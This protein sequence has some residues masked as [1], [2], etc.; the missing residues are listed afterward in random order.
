MR[1]YQINVCHVYIINYHPTNFLIVCNKKCTNGS[2]DKQCTNCVCEKGFTGPTCQGQFLQQLPT[3]IFHNSW[4]IE[5]CR[6]LD[7]TSFCEERRN[8]GYCNHYKYKDYM[9]DYCADTCGLCPTTH[10]PTQIPE[11]KGKTET[12]QL[13]YNNMISIYCIVSLLILNI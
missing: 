8:A 4:P 13:W 1:R 10:P 11:I 6:D 12:E 7:K 2:P 5:A 9:N 3:Y